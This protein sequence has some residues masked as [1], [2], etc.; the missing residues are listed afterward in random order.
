MSIDEQKN[1]AVVR[2][3]VY[4]ANQDYSIDSYDEIVL[5]T[6]FERYFTGGPLDVQY[7]QNH[8]EF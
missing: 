5:E 2:K 4:K 1:V 7:F 8:Y 6:S 3:Y